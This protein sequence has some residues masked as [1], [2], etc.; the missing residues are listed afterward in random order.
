MPTILREGPYRIFFFSNEGS[1]PAHVHVFSNGKVAKLWLSNT[2]V[3]AN[4]GFAAH[5]LTEIIQL[6]RAHRDELA[7]AWD[8]YFGSTGR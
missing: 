1:E 8:G 4:S 6:V 2:A 3:A 5:E 7:R